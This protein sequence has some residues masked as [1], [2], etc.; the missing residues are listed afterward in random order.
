MPFSG[1]FSTALTHIHQIKTKQKN[2]PQSTPCCVLYFS[3]TQVF[4]ENNWL[5]A[6]RLL[7]NYLEFSL[8]LPPSLPRVHVCWCVCWCAHT[9]VHM[10]WSRTF[11]CSWFYPVT[12]WDP[13]DGTG[14]GLSSLLTNT[15][16]NP[17]IHLTGPSG[18]PFGFSLC[19]TP[20]VRLSNFSC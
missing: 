3:F 7:Q 6:L 19:S 4:R 17:L 10:C 11:L 20:S 18:L 15:S 14:L 9:T 1:L 12:L 5:L 16:L 13:E 8:F 2:P